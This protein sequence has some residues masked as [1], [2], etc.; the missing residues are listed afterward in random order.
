M[1]FTIIKTHMLQFQVKE[2]ASISDKIE[3]IDAGKISFTNNNVGVALLRNSLLQVI[4]YGEMVLKPAKE[5][6]GCWKCI[7]AD[8]D[9]PW[10]K[11]KVIR[12]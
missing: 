12:N 1:Y 5:R 3:L 6:E 2:K 7:R 4:K 11:V 9:Q 10:T 8:G